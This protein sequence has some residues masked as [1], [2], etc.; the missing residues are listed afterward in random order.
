M[1]RGIEPVD[2]VVLRDGEKITIEN[3]QFPQ[4][5]ESG[6]VFGNLDFYVAPEAKTFGS[7]IKHS[8]VRSYSTIKMIWEQLYDLATGRYSLESISGPVGVTQALEEAAKSGVGN[9]V[10]L[11]VFISINLGVMNLLPIPALDGGRLVFQFIE[12]IRRKPVPV[13]VEGYIHFAGLVILMAV[14][15][16]V[17]FKDITRLFG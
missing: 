5:T 9:L 10:Y 8:I 14:L 17:T 7:V 1:R 11:S 12:L 16:L 3:V 4:I 13:E 6:T 15:V 2:V